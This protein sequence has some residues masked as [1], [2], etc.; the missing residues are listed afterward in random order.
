[1]NETVDAADGAEIRPAHVPAVQYVEIAAQ[2]FE[3]LA[4]DIVVR[5]L[6]NGCC[7]DLSSTRENRGDRDGRS[8]SAADT[9]P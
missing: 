9:V 1:M 3:N 8:Q 4:A 5:P 2:V 7:S 6:F